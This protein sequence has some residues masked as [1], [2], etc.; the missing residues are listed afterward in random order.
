MAAPE[1][2]Q[3]WQARSTHGRKRAYDDRDEFED[4][5]YQY[6]AWCHE[7]PLKEQKVFN[8]KD[9]IAKTDCNLMRAMTVRGL[10]I[11]L[12]ISRDTWYRYRAGPETPETGETE[13][14]QGENAADPEEQEADPPVDFS[15]ICTMVE[16]IIYTQKFEGAA[17]GLLNHAIIARHLGL[18][19]HKKVTATVDG[20]FE[21]GEAT[22]MY[23]QEIGREDD[24]ELEND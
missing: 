21:A 2:N 18:A 22:K 23:L 14:D 1:G 7:N 9:G 12:G 3:F 20:T 13:A 16:E 17:A 24:D 15:D 6:F 4:A 8:G 5:C 10:C 11:F 19:E